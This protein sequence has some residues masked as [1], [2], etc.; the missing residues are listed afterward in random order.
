MA[1]CSTA[2]CGC[3][4]RRATVR[5]I[6]PAGRMSGRSKG[7][8]G[9][10]RYVGELTLALVFYL[11]ILLL[12]L[13]RAHQ[14]WRLPLRLLVLGA[15]RLLFLLRLLPADRRHLRLDRLPLL[16]LPRLHIL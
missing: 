7:R 4:F 14:R 12:G 2:G 9:G 6:R 16:L 1:A 8:P 3:D 13:A 15:L 5:Q 10:P 11:F